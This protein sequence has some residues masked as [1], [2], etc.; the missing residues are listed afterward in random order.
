M[1]TSSA[2]KDSDT[3]ILAS[4]VLATRRAALKWHEQRPDHRPIR[5]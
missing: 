1:I 5:Y 4:R 3:S 2:G